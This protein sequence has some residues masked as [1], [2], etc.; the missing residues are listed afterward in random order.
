M[1]VESLEPDVLSDPDLGWVASGK[2]GAPALVAFGGLRGGLMMPPF[3][4]FRTVKSLD[5]TMVM[6]RDLAQVWYLQGVAGLADSLLG[7]APALSEVLAEFAPARTVVTGN[8]AG[9]YMA[10]LVGAAL[11]AERVVAFSPQTYLDEERR[12][13]HS[14]RRWREEIAHRRSLADHDLGEDLL[15]LL[16]RLPGPGRAEVYFSEHHAR[17]ASHAERLGRIPWVD[18]RPLDSD[19]HRAILHLKR[20]GVLQSLLLDALGSPTVHSAPEADAQP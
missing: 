8:S 20:S 7:V 2:S 14:D 11:Q 12:T 13:R 9:A 10:M 3:E 18:L 17:D 19:D 5:V 16:E 4:F 6:I 15:P 1:I